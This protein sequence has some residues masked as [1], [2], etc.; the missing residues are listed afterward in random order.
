M[1]YTIEKYSNED[2]ERNEKK[3]CHRAHIGVS[4]YEIKADEYF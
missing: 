4:R 3:R 1:T 2:N